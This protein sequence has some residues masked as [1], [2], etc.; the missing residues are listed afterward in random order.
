MLWHAPLRGWIACQRPDRLTAANSC[1]LRCVGTTFHTDIAARGGLENC[2]ECPMPPDGLRLAVWWVGWCPIPNLRPLAFCPIAGRGQIG[3]L[4]VRSGRRTW[5]CAMIWPNRRVISIAERHHFGRVHAMRY[6]GVRTNPAPVYHGH[7]STYST[8]LDANI[9]LR[10]SGFDARPLARLSRC[11]PVPPAVC[12]NV[13][14]QNSN[15][16]GYDTKNHIGDS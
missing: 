8:F 11:P 14:D 12:P 13:T 7:R 4:A 3:V 6:C 16:A 5:Y 2:Q 1:G 9:S 10:L 15:R